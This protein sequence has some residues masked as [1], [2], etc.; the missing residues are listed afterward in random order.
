[1]SAE[2]D[3]WGRSSV[4]KPVRDAAGLTESTPGEA[5]VADGIILL[6]PL[7]GALAMVIHSGV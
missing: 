3:R 2:V 1:M 5:E 6:R 4:P 7:H